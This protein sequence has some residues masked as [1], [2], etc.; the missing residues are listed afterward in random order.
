LLAR[1]SLGLAG[2]RLLGNAVK[3]VELLVPRHQLAVLQRQ[4]GRPK[5]EAGDRV[6]PAALSRL[7]PRQ[8]WGS[9]F[10]P[11]AALLRW[12]REL[13]ADGWTYPPRGPVGRRYRR[14]QG[15]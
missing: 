1:R 14:R 10:V 5:L 6:L 15:S 9:F 7:L 8:R 11:P 12:H 13:I 2:L 4:V 3:D